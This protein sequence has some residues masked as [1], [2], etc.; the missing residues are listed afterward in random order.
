MVQKVQNAEVARFPLVNA[1]LPKSTDN[2]TMKVIKAATAVFT[3]PVAFIVDILNKVVSYFKA[4]KIEVKQGRLAKA[5]NKSK[6]GAAKVAKW[7]R[8]HPYIAGAAVAGLA[9][10]GAQ[11]KPC[12]RSWEWSVLSYAPNKVM[13]YFSKAAEVKA[14]SHSLS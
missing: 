11:A 2:T 9:F 7:V 13:G 6:D 12:F 1:L 10:A 8:A 14:S 3:V 5:W 4:E